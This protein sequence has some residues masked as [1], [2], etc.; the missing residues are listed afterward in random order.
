MYVARA[1]HAHLVN[2]GKKVLV[3]HGKR[4]FLAKVKVLGVV[5]HKVGVGDAHGF[6][7]RQCNAIKRHVS[8]MENQGQVLSEFHTTWCGNNGSF[9]CLVP[10][11]RDVVNLLGGNRVEQHAVEGNRQVLDVPKLRHLQARVGDGDGTT[12]L[13]P[14]MS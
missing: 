7:T 11:P 1:N 2:R 8:V 13:E 3:A 4:L 14:V 12:R 10:L 9:I 5:V 6:C